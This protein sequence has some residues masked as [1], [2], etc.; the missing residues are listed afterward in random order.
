L[1]GSDEKS[2]RSNK[3]SQ[4][5][6]KSIRPSTLFNQSL[7]ASGGRPAPAAMVPQNDAINMSIQ[8]Q[9]A[10]LNQSNLALQMEITK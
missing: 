5:S 1:D 10:L 8:S 6:Q 7:L 2:S 4:K 9:A 3:K